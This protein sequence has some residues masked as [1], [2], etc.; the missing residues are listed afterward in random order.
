[1]YSRILLEP[2]LKYF[3]KGKAIILLGPRQT[4]KTTLSL[5]LLEFF[6]NKKKIGIFNCD[7][8]EDRDRLNEKNLE[9]LIGLV[10]DLDIVLIDE[11]Q[12]V[13]TIGQT[14][15]LLVDH[16]KDKKQF[17]ITGSSSFNLLDKTGEALTGRKLVFDLLPLSLEEIYPE[18]NILKISKEL[19]NHLIFGSYPE[20]VWQK[21][22]ERKRRFLKE[23]ATSYLF[24]DIL[25]FQKIKKSDVLFKL[26][27]ALAL[28]I[29][30]EVSFNELSNIV[31]IDKKTVEKYI[32]LLEKNFIIFK[33]SPYTKNKRREIMKS[34]KIYFYDLGIRN[35]IIN[36]FNFLSD[37][38]DAG[39][40]WEN[41]V[42]VERLKYQNYHNIY[43][44]NYFWRT[45]DGS[46]IDW[47]EER[48]GKLFGYEIK[49]NKNR[50]ATVPSKWK[51][52]S[53]GEYKIISKENLKGFIF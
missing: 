29:G 23:L 6:K 3:F 16:Y 32:D 19:E 49:W 33:L 14:S 28:Q 18:K 43:S 13:E 20:I 35:E 39:A 42:A 17:V 24:K 8:P 25:E 53:N 2:I 11:G 9:S 10:D 15:K 37:R 38:N 41:F 34:K 12:K 4:G 40:L 36:N 26:L 30:S 7:N 1:M 47:I 22:F 52:Y 51:E 46:E 27:K 50:R 48:D 21:S 44:H 31:G 45:Y 5:A